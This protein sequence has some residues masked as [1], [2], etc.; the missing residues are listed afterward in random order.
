MAREFAKAFY[1]SAAWQI[2]RAAYIKRVAGLCEDCLAKGLYVPGKVVHHTILLTPENINDPSVS[3]NFENLRYV[4]Q[5][6]HAAEHSRPKRYT[7]DEAGHVV[8][9]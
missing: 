6:C 9:S 1:K 5:N 2:C 4:C 8:K 3:L 7:F